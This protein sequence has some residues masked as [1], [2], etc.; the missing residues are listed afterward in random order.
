LAAIVLAGGA[1]RRFGGGKL[2]AP[3]RQ[4][5]LIE[6]ALDSAFAAPVRS[7]ILVTGADPG[8]TAVAIEHALTEGEIGRLKVVHADDHAEGMAASLRAGVAALPLGAAGVFVFLGDMPLIPAG[9][10]DDLARALTRGFLAAVPVFGGRRGHP[11]LFSAALFD[12]LLGLTG[13]EG[14]RSILKRLGDRVAEAP[15]ASEGVLFDVD[16]PDALS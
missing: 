11:A 3:W 2:L 13:E 10:T 9:I 12:D 4:G 7:V 8:V 15:A 1:G 5:L 6:A 14:A 16:T